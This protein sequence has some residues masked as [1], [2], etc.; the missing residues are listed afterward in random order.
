V[1]ARIIGDWHRGQIPSLTDH[2]TPFFAAQR[3]ATRPCLF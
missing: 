3:I 2:R 1:R